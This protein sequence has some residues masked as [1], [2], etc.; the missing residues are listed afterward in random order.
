MLTGTRCV[1][2]NKNKMV[3]PAYTPSSSAIAS[4]NDLIRGGRK[5]GGER[6]IIDKGTESGLSGASKEG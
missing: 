1:N 6:Y 2:R 4:P 3:L 5:E